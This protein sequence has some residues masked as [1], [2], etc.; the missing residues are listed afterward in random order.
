MPITSRNAKQLRLQASS[1]K[2]LLIYRSQSPPTP[3][4]GALD[5]LIKGCHMAMHSAVHLAEENRALRDANTKQKQ[6]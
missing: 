1:V 2:A 6:K 5:Q 4:K 3:T